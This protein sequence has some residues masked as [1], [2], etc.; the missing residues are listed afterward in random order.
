MLLLG[1]RSP[2]LSGIRYKLSG[3]KKYLRE[4]FPIL[5]ASGGTPRFRMSRLASYLH[6]LRSRRSINNV[7]S[8]A[9]GNISDIFLRARI[10]EGDK[11]CAYKA[12]R[13][14][15]RGGLRGHI[16]LRACEGTRG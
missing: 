9:I 13:M 3:H 6:E 16:S 12:A 1:S 14:S 10:L 15:Q 8:F 7:C 5:S 2:Q 11:G 4:S